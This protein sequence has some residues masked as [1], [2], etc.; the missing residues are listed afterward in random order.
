MSAND[1]NVSRSWATM[2]ISKE[3]MALT[4]ETAGSRSLA[5]TSRSSSLEV[6]G[7]DQANSEF[8]KDASSEAENSPHL[9]QYIR[10]APA[11]GRPVRASPSSHGPKRLTKRAKGAAR[12]RESTS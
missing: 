6:V 11:N 7:R 3:G 12:R 4:G 5:D 9:C 8:A 10:S 1:W 2:A